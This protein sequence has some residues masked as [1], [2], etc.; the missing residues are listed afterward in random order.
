MS[1]AVGADLLTD[2]VAANLPLADESNNATIELF[3]GKSGRSRSS[4]GSGHWKPSC[5][6]TNGKELPS[7]F[8]II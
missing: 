8:L 5:V 3:L 7:S 6:R 1:E 4:S 2:I